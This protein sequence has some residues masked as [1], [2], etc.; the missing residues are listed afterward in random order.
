MP[1]IK[2]LSDD[3]RDKVNS[4]VYNVDINLN[5]YT[6]TG[7]V[8]LVLL[9]SELEQINFT[10][11]SDYNTVYKI[12]IIA[13]E[14]RNKNLTIGMKNVKLNSGSYSA[15]DIRGTLNQNYTSTINY[16]GINHIKSEGAVTIYV[17]NNQTINI[18]GLDSDSILNVFGGLECCAIG[19]A[20]IF[21]YG[22]KI[23]FSGLGKV[24][25]VGGNGGEVTGYGSILER[26]NGGKGG[27]AV[28]IVSGKVIIENG[29]EL[30][31]GNGTS[32]GE[33]NKELPVAG[34]D[35]GT[36]GSPSALGDAVI[37]VKG[38]DTPGN[39]GSNY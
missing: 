12:R 38:G 29:G 34:G 14:E 3:I 22:G 20:P 28:S 4:G 36:G 27:N 21:N 23:I 18:N 26:Q 10:V 2:Q 31:G 25:A 32:L 19:N 17:T 6:N 30:Q 9:P 37:D 1:E 11:L 8:E 7:E 13:N 24:T 35:G 5:D 33:N 39:G 16:S 15:I